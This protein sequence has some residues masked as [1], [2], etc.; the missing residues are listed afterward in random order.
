MKNS[1]ISDLWHLRDAGKLA[2]AREPRSL[3][4]AG[5]LQYERLQLSDFKIFSNLQ[6]RKQNWV[7]FKNVNL[8]D[9]SLYSELSCSP[10]FLNHGV[11]GQLSGLR[12]IFSYS[13]LDRISAKGKILKAEL[14]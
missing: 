12:R 10:N 14:S 11:G 6:H 8:S 4:S 3:S 13:M 5:Y 9:R 1:C 7:H 2:V